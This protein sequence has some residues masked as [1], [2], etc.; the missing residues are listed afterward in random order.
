MFSLA[1]SLLGCMG[2]RVQGGA[3][4]D[5]GRAEGLVV[6]DV[7][8]DV[9]LGPKTSTRAFGTFDVQHIDAQAPCH[10]E[11]HLGVRGH[12]AQDRAM[13]GPAVGLGGH[14]HLV[15][16]LAA[17]GNLG[18]KLFELGAQDQAFAAGVT[19]PYAQLGLRLTLTEGVFLGLEGLGGYDLR[20]GRHSYP[21]VGGMARFTVGILP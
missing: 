6:A 4:Q 14:C 3:A 2:L 11:L 1:L 13:T 17:Q 12:Y 19:S 15:G 7:G 18:V 10:Y 8:L 16:P 5:L 21:Y 9:T 20:P